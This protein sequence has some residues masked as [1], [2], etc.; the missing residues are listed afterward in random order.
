MGLGVSNGVDIRL[1]SINEN[2]P[3]RL[4][5]VLQGFLM[6][7]F[8]S[9]EIMVAFSTYSADTPHLYL[10]L[11]RAKAESLGVSVSNVFTTLQ[12]YL[13]S[14]YVNDVNIGNQVN[15]VM[16]QADWPYRKAKEDI[17]N[18]T[19]KSDSGAMVPVS[20]LAS[21]RATAAPRRVLRF[22]QF[23]AA[24][25]TAMPA[26][27]VSSGAAMK[28][29]ERIARESLPRG[30]TVDW[31]GM[32]YQEAKVE[33]QGLVLMGLSLIFG[34]LF[35]VAQ[36][37]SW[38]IPVPVMLSIVVAVAG[39][40]FGIKMAGL[41]L[42]IYA[43]LG[44]ILL[45]G[46]ASKNAILIVEFCKVEREAGSSIL[47]AAR[48]GLYERF[49]AVLMTAFTFILGTLPMVFATGAG[50]NSRLAIGLTVCAGMTAATVLGILVVPPLYVMFQSLREYLKGKFGTK[51]AASGK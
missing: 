41:P 42:S 4:G 8:Q 18:L 14:R 12:N 17:G 45:V 28:A 50:A 33:S 27:G 47:E 48:A 10:D 31:S 19:V 20:S 23:P 29:V 26:P 51:M 46:L 44:L 35:L 34:Y 15:K 13:G 16:V 49:R 21:I 32:S 11:D 25:I 40:L 22:N 39:A 38:T 43:Q 3:Q 24:S 5:Q 36:Y 37:E 1:Q 6:R 2:D 30:Y 7:L 9:P